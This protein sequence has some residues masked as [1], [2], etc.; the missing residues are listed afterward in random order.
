MA[1]Q[2]LPATANTVSIEIRATPSA[3]VTFD[4]H[5]AGR[6]P[7]TIHVPKSANEITIGAVLLGHP[8]TRTVVPDR[9]QT[10]D[11]KYP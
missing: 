4:G 10:V 11:F 1:G 8:L 7:L 3:T 9:D 6:T 2:R 5:K